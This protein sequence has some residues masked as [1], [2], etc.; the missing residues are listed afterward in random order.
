MI[1]INGNGRYLDLG[2][3]RNRRLEE[4]FVIRSFRNLCSSP[5]NIRVM[6]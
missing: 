3:G 4:N 2:G 6:K 5:H 1:Y